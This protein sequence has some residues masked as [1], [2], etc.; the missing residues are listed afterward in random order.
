MVQLVRGNTLERSRAGFGEVLVARL[1]CVCRC[2][3]EPDR[4]NK[5]GWMA[6][7]AARAHF[8]FGAGRARPVR[9]EFRIDASDHDESITAG[10]WDQ[11]LGRIWT[12]TMLP[13]WHCGHWRSERPVRSS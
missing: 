10:S 9:R 7:G 12:R 8:F 11:D 6:E 3:W 13:C 1:R 2:P 5:R 4:Q